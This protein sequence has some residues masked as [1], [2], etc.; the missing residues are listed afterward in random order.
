MSVKPE[1]HGEIYIMSDQR[2]L[3]QGVGQCQQFKNKKM[4]VIGRE[5][6]QSVNK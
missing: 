3:L 6:N 4:F 5:G 2:K 1:Q